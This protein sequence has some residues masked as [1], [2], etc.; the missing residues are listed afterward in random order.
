MAAGHLPSGLRD[1]LG[2]EAALGL[3]EQLNDQR[4][5]WSEQVL[6]IAADRF[7]CRL[8]AE[9][10]RLRDDFH[11]A[12]DGVKKELSA[13]RVEILKWSFVFWIGQI[14]IVSTLVALLLRR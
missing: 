6:S 14:A 12:L 11:G 13:T 4:N 2:P 1:W 3:L 9:A 5:D 7:D 8:A 10:S